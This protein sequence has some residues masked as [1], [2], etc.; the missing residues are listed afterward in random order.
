MSARRF[1]LVFS[2]VYALALSLGAEL[3][4]P[5]YRPW[6]MLALPDKTGFEPNARVTMSAIGDLGHE[7]GIISLQTPRDI[8]WTTDRFGFRNP[9]RSA[10]SPVVVIGD[11]FVA[12]A[13]LDDADTL[14]RQ[15]E[16][17]LGVSVYNRG[18]ESL[19]GPALYLSDPRF[20]RFPPRVVI[21]CPTQRGLEPRGLAP[22]RAQ[23]LDSPAFPDRIRRALGALD[24]DNGLV[25]VS[26]ETFNELRYRLFGA[27]WVGR[28][29]GEDR[30]RL[31]VEVARLHLTSEVRRLSR[32]IQMLSALATLLHERGSK[33]V[34]CPI[35][36]AG[37]VYPE[38]Y[39]PRDRARMVEPHHIDRVVEAAQ[40]A[41]LEVV[42]LSA[43]F[44]AHR[45]P[46]LWWRDD[47]HWSPRAVEL[48]ADAL[49]P[50]VATYLNP[51][52]D[53]DLPSKGAAAGG[54]S[55]KSHP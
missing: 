2:L 47:S 30:L 6:E 16:A 50:R 13:G 41:G 32:T 27:P 43:L 18:T 12:G 26:R 52:E 40:R 4:T 21:W 14:A 53:P 28:F 51:A 46:Y 23:P 49:A 8:T 35:P 1:I 17:R 7:S 31:P 55:P 36:D 5:Y 45:R 15:L 25:R 37:N 33:L 20:A 24:R 3:E 9:E 39:S 34:Y 48:A 42:D 10:P 38:L 19:K 54:G 11:S 29:D 22:P 44:R